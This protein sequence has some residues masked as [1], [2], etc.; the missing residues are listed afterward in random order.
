VVTVAGSAGRLEVVTD[1][2][3]VFAVDLAQLLPLGQHGQL[4]VTASAGGPV[5]TLMMDTR[6]L[7]RGLRQLPP[8]EDRLDLA[9]RWSFQPGAHPDATSGAA[10]RVPGHIAFD[11]H[12]PDGGVATLCR[13]FTVPPSFLDSTVFL[14]CDAVYGRAE[15]YL[16]GDRVGSH[17]AGA[18]SFDLE[19]TPYLRPGANTLALVITEYTPHAVLDNMSWYAHMSLLGIW[20]PVFLFRTPRAH[21]GPAELVADWDPVAGSGALHVGV[22]VINLDAADQA[23]RIELALTEVST[24][25]G[26]PT[27]TVWTGEREGQVPAAASSRVEL[28]ADLPGVRPWSDELPRLYTVDMALTTA[29]GRQAYRRRVG[30]RRVEVRGDRL[31]VNGAAVRL[32]GINRHDSRMTTG[33]ALTIDD[34]RTDLTLLRQANVNTIRTS[35]YPPDPRMLD[36]C[37]ELG[38]YVF[39]SLP[40]CFSGGFD[41]HHWNRTNDAANLVPYAWEVTAETLQRDRN[42]CSV[43]AWDL[44]NESRWSAGFAANLRM[45]RALDSTRPSMFSYDLNALPENI[46]PAQ[47]LRPELRSYHYPGWNRTWQED[48]AW[49]RSVGEPVVLDEFAPLFQECIRSSLQASLIGMDPGVRDYWVTGYR[50]IIEAA[51][52]DNGCIGGMIWSAVDDVFALPLDLRVGEGPWAHLP[53]A[54]FGI[55]R[56]IN[57]GYPGIS[58]RGDAEWGP[59]DGFGR[60]RPEM[61]HILKLYSPVRVALD[62]RTAEKL[63]LSVHNRS[64]HRDLG[65]IGLVVRGASGPQ[66]LAAGP[67]E[68]ETVVLDLAPDAARVTLELYRP[69]G[70]LLDAYGWDGAAPAPGVDTLLDECA[71]PVR[72]ELGPDGDLSVV[73]R[74][75][76]L[77]G[78]PAVTVVD[79][80]RPDVRLDLP[81]SDP[82]SVAGDHTGITARLSAP[83]WSGTMS[84]RVD[85]HRVVVEY[86]CQ[87]LGSE[88]FHAREVGLT[89][90][91]PADHTDLWWR[92][93][94]DWSYYPAGHIGRSAGYAPAAP[95]PADVLHPAPSWDQDTTPAGTNDYRSTKRTLLGVGA[96]DGRTTVSVLSGGVQHARAELRAGEPVLHVL[97]WYG[98][99]RTVDGAHEV[100]SSY[101]GPGQRIGP[102][103]ELRGT[104]VIAC[105]DLP[106]ELRG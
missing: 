28:A 51:V 60:T 48:L 21:L 18:T 36:L 89:L 80:N 87:Y 32:R 77:R 52:Q 62:G 79:A 73:G 26:Q 14:R 81:R 20:R 106:T 90:R 30:F 95:G 35:H 105:G 9:G 31:L 47:R 71:E 99:V 75:P 43:I 104:S 19:L 85:G 98:G 94:G 76:W 97:D 17:G 45:V 27:R 34:L 78:W 5:R 56:V 101:V 49:L 23:Y 64:S 4:T 66:R 54:D 69:D 83:D 61:W 22:D 41:D 6:D 7:A 39:D 70:S 88:P 25:D 11:G 46:L 82:A 2:L 44:G 92:R 100:W 37:D 86:A 91:P 40:I 24:V 67:G 96:T 38:I 3:G 93:V 63:T 33:R 29:S 58:F 10:T 59:I 42:H 13:T 84:I 1:G 74:R 50:D 12:V 57:P 53:K 55:N 8:D 15:V 103:T 72:L 65:D 16:N 68:A 102:G